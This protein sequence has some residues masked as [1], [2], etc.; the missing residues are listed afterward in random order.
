MPILETIWECGKKIQ[1]PKEMTRNGFV[2]F[3]ALKVT[4]GTTPRPVLM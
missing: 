3:A 2:C 1:E 4:T